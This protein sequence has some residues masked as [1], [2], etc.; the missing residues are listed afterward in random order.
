M[1]PM[2]TGTRQLGSAAA[3]CNASG[4]DCAAIASDCHAQIAT[5]TPSPATNAILA[6]LK[7]G[8]AEK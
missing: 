6:G 3:A 8:P 5:V 4:L 2:G 7:A 1:L